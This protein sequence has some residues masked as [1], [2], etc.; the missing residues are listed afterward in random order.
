MAILCP[1]D[2]KIL[3]DDIIDEV[4][5]NAT[6]ITDH[7]TRITNNETT[8][9]DH[10]IRI[11]ALETNPP[12]ANVPIGGIVMYSGAFAD[13]PPEWV[14][15]DGTNGTP[16]LSGQ[17]IRGTIYEDQIGVT[18]GSAD[19]IVVSHTH[20][21]SSTFTGNAMGEHSHVIPDQD[22]V[23]LLSGQIS[24]STTDGNASYYGYTQLATSG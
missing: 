23:R 19:A 17:F 20:T 8:I 16:D 15:C 1:P 6:S 12:P 14:L 21:A 24:I 9:A 2:G 4:N 22:I 18:G 5:N 13:I 10:E 11:T 7:E 3:I